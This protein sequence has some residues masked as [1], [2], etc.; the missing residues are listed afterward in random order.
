MSERNLLSAASTPN[1]EFDELERLA[2]ALVGAEQVRDLQDRLTRSMLTEG[3][4]R[5]AGNYTQTARLLGVRRQAIQQMVSRF[6]LGEWAASLRQ[7]AQRLD[8]N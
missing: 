3:L 8:H 1:L 5:T 4:R 6:A 7:A 2:K